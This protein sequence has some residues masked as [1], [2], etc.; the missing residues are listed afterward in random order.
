MILMIDNYDS[1]TYNLVQLLRVTGQDVVVK[2]NDKITI[3]EI[4]Q[5]NPKAIVISPGPSSP[6][7]SGIS[8]KIVRELQNRF[9]ILGICLGYQVIAEAFGSQIIKGVPTHGKVQ[10]IKNSGEGVFYNL[11][12]KFNIT[13]YHS[14][15]IDKVPDNFTV[16]ATTLGG[17]IMGIKHK[18]LKIEGVQFHPE[19]ILSEYG[20]E[21]I[22]NFTQWL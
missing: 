21:I 18:S 1:F 15:K 6:K 12:S 17:E 22:K 8:Y 4:L 2:K 10:K 7:Q 9:P 3:P 14:L 13:R 11:P 16:T 20:V 19:A 5:L